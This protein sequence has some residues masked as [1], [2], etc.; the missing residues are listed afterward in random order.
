MKSLFTAP[1]DFVKD[2]WGW[3]TNQL[4]W[5]LLRADIL[6]L[7]AALDLRTSTAPVSSRLRDGYFPYLEAVG[8]P[9]DVSARI[10]LFDDVVADQP[11]VLGF[12]ILNLPG[13]GTRLP[14]IIVQPGGALFHRHIVWNQ[15]WPHLHAPRGQRCGVL[16]RGDGQT[17]GGIRRSAIPS[18]P[19]WPP[20]SGF[21]LPAGCDAI[22]PSL[23]VRAAPGYATRAWR[24]LG[25]LAVGTTGGKL[26]FT[27]GLAP[28]GLKF[29]LAAGDEDGLLAKLLG[30]S[31]LE[32]PIAL[33]IRWSKQRGLSFGASGGFE[34]SVPLNQ[35]LGPLHLRSGESLAG[36]RHHP[37]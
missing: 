1:G 22:R 34:V 28:K 17:K 10:D 4:N 2:V 32:S 6:E 12:N 8:Q 15:R 19:A 5:D 26:D 7:G 21:R 3:G 36:R 24:L 33:Q 30:G 25:R 37:G 23:A 20:H 29:F 13:E 31:K 14:G 27:V 35:D 16:V 9:T 18:I 11:V